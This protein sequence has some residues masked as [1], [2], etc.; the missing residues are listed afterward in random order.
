MDFARLRQFV[1][2]GELRRRLR[3]RNIQHTTVP[4]KKRVTM[5]GTTGRHDTCAATCIVL[6]QPANVSESATEQSFPQTSK[7]AS[8]R[9]V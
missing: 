3:S 1:L 4:R 9:R 5:S 6:H 8:K 7:S 2:K